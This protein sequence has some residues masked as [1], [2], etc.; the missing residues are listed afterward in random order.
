M[1]TLKVEAIYIAKYDTYEDVAA[2][3]PRFIGKIYNAKRQYSAWDYLSPIQFK[4]HIGVDNVTAPRW[5]GG[6]CSIRQSGDKFAP[7]PEMCQALAG[8]NAT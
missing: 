8:Q 2:D 5:Q 6:T 3:L 1:K 4:D 7:K